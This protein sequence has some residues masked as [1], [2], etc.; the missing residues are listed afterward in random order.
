LGT[1]V[2]EKPTGYD[3]AQPVYSGPVRETP[4]GSEPGSEPPDFSKIFSDWKILVL[5][6]AVLFLVLKD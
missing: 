6:G 5:A 3:A 4:P 2:R 1:P